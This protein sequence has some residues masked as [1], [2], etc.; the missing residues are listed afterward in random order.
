MTEPLKLGLAGLGTVGGGVLRLL[1]ERGPALAKATGRPIEIVAVSARDRRKNR[2]SDISGFRFVAGQTKHEVEDE[3]RIVDDRRGVEVLRFSA[4]SLGKLEWE[5]AP[6][7]IAL[8]TGTY[9]MEWRRR[10]GKTWFGIVKGYEFDG[11]KLV[12]VKF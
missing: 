7:V 3:V 11:N 1:A 10:E 6:T 8:P 2:C 12:D 9:T 5:D 4:A